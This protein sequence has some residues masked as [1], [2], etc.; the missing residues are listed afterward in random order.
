VTMTS[1]KN[2]IAKM[3]KPVMN[4]LQNRQKAVAG[5]GRQYVCRSAAPVQPGFCQLM[6][7]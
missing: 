7:T 2:A 5:R 6:I 3:S 1:S 4:S